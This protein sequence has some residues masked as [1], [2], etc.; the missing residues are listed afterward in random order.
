VTKKYNELNE[1]TLN[2][3]EKELNGRRRKEEEYQSLLKQRDIEMNLL[4]TQL[5]GFVAGNSKRTHCSQEGVC[6]C[7][8][9]EQI[10]VGTQSKDRK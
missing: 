2:D 9:S 8:K 4:K 5:A 10:F 6:K 1:L 7:I 3:H